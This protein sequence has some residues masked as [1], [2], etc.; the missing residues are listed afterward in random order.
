MEFMTPAE[1][2]R[3]LG[4]AERTRVRELVRIGYSEAEARAAAAKE[5][6]AYDLLEVDDRGRVRLTGLELPY[7]P[8]VSSRRGQ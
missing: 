8:D 7:E 6:G 5:F 2:Q 4:S 1:L 3:R